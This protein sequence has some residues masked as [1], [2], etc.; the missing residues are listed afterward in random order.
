MGATDDMAPVSQRSARCCW[1]VEGFSC[2]N[3]VE[4]VDD[5]EV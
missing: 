3:S 4:H 5:R 2:R 1:H